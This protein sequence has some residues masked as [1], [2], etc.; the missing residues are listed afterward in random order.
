MITELEKIRSDV[1]ALM[2]SEKQIYLCITKSM[3]NSLLAVSYQMVVEVSRE[4]FRKAHL[5]RHLTP[6]R[7]LDYQQHYNT[8]CN[9]LIRATLKQQSSS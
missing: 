6:E 8:L 2:Q 7:I 3:L 4:G 1:T 5:R 9:A